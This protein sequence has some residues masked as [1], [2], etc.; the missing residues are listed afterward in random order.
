MSASDAIAAIRNLNGGKLLGDELQAILD[1]AGRLV[2][3]HADANPAYDM[4]TAG[5]C[6]DEAADAFREAKLIPEPA[7]NLHRERVAAAR[8]GGVL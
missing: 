3:E 2:A 6:A 5:Q 4:T 7:I 8:M 1:I